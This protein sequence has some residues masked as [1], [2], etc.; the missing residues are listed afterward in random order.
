[1]L[2][3]GLLVAGAGT[4]LLALSSVR[5]V[6]TGFIGTTVWPHP[7][8]RLANLV[9]WLLLIGG[10]FLQYLHARRTSRSAEPSRTVNALIAVL[11]RRGLITQAEVTEE[12]RNHR[13]PRGQ[14]R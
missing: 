13:Q 4:V 14:G 9:G 7:G 8:W 3:A 6:V 12:I 10:F 2:Q 11:E 5:G 1:M